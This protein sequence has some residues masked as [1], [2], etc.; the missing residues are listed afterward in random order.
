MLRH[1]QKGTPQKQ[2]RQGKVP[3]VK[4]A[5]NQ[6]FSIASGRDVHV[7]VPVLKSKSDEL[8]KKLGHNDFRATDGWLSRWK[9]SFGIKFKKAHGEKGSADAV[10][11]EQWKA[12]KLTNV[13]QKFCTDD[14]YKADEIGLPY[15]ATPDSS[16]SY[17]HGTS[18]DRSPILPYARKCAWMIPDIFKKWL[19]GWEVQLQRKWSKILLVLDNCAEHPHFDSLNICLT[20]SHPWHN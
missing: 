7:S 15:R 19:M 20:V 18:T 5:L 10:S 6:C 12:T 2:K 13:L 11:A 16:L 9:C 8:A 4:E 3:D 1:G 14:I 17:K